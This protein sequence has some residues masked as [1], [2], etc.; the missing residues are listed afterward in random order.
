MAHRQILLHDHG[1]PTRVTPYCPNLLS[2][3]A[4]RAYRAVLVDT[5][6]QKELVDTLNETRSFLLRLFLW[7]NLYL[8]LG[9]PCWRYEVVAVKVRVYPHK[10]IREHVD[11][12]YGDHRKRQHPLCD[13]ERIDMSKPRSSVDFSDVLTSSPTKL[14][15]FNDIPGR[16]WSLP[17]RAPQKLCT[18]DDFSAEGRAYDHSY[19]VENHP[20]SAVSRHVQSFNQHRMQARVNTSRE[21]A[22]SQGGNRTVPQT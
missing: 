10:G 6:F 14:D 11:E 7:F 1:F 2:C 13:G 19:L 4:S 3:H 12:E 5:F 20:S 17:E 21:L 8:N 18:I 22:S 16:D 9:F 15:K